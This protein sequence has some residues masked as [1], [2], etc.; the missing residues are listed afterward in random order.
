MLFPDSDL[1]TIREIVNFETVLQRF[2]AG[3]TSLVTPKAG[4]IKTN[5]RAK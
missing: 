3:E 1:V 4:P 5:F 2:V